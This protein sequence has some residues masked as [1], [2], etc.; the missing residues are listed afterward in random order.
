MDPFTAAMTLGFFACV[1]TVG[2]GA[3]VGLGEKPTIIAS[4]IVYFIVG[5]MLL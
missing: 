4:L 1:M 2:V 5:S 3:A